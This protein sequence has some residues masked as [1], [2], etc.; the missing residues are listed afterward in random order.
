[1]SEPQNWQDDNG[2]AGVPG[3]NDTAIFDGQSNDRSCFVDGDRS[4]DRITMTA[5][6]SRHILGS[7]SLTVRNG[8]SQSGGTIANSLFRIAAGTFE[9]TNGAMSNFVYAGAQTEVM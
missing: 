8:G 5:G 3:Q 7:G 6:F 1:W 9:W 2:A 4:V